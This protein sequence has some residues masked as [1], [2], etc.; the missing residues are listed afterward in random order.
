MWSSEW[1]LI[2]IGQWVS[3]QDRI[4]CDL[5]YHLLQL[6]DTLVTDRLNQLWHA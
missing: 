1:G 6:E 4:G 5:V 3:S 2:W